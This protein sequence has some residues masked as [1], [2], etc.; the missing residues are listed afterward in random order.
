MSKSIIQFKNRIRTQDLTILYDTGC[1]ECRLPLWQLNSFIQ[2][3][4]SNFPE[5]I[6]F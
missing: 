3:I 2:H 1:N 6:I 4:S 5:S